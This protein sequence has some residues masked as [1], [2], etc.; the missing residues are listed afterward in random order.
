MVHGQRSCRF[1]GFSDGSPRHSQF[2]R[3]RHFR[4]ISG[5]LSHVAIH[6]GDGSSTRRLPGVSYERQ[7]KQK[8][9]PCAV[10]VAEDCS[11]AKPSVT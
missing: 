7:R 8:E 9:D 2:L 6:H 10:N 5:R 4:S 11:S 3:I 1:A